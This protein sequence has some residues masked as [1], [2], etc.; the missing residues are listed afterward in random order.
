[1]Q[2]DSPL[3]CLPHPAELC[4]VVLHPLVL[5][6]GLEQLPHLGC[7]PGEEGDVLVELIYRA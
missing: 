7:L 1:M 3:G 6:V 2:G 4:L 5:G